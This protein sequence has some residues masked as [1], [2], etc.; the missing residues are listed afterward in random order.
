MSLAGT[1]KGGDTEIEAA[2]AVRLVLGDTSHLRASLE[3]FHTWRVEPTAEV[4]PGK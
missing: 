1:D 4:S 3:L 2:T